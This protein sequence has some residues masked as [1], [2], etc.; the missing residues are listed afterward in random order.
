M[1]GGIRINIPKEYRQCMVFASLTYGLARD[2][3]GVSFHS[4]WESL[5]KDT[6][7]SF[8]ARLGCLQG[9]RRA[10][11]GSVCFVCL[12]VVQLQRIVCNGAEQEFERLAPLPRTIKMP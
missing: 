8:F 3:R 4:R 11:W 9:Q 12:L 10:I 7:G 6:S 5:G 2:C 1:Q